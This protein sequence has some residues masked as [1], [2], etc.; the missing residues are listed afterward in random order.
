MVRG[1]QASPCPQGGLSP[2]CDRRWHPRTPLLPPP[3]PESGLPGSELCPLQPPRRRTPY[4][5]QRGLRKAWG[6]PWATRGAVAKPGLDLGCLESPPLGSGVSGDPLAPEVQ[7]PWLYY[8]R[9]AA[10]SSGQSP[11]RPPAPRRPTR[12]RASSCCRLSLPSA[13][14]SW[15][16]SWNSWSCRSSAF[17]ASSRTCFRSASFSRRLLECCACSS[18]RVAMACGDHGAGDPSPEPPSPPPSAQSA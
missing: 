9:A 13:A 11:R 5:G 10:L 3:N 16:S 8:G 6:L 1:S 2:G 14:S 18:S 4:R 12:T 17:S 15:P 7:S